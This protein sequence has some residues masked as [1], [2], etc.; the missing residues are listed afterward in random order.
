MPEYLSLP[1]LSSGVAFECVNRSPFHARYLQRNRDLWLPKMDI[2]TVAHQIL[3]ENSEDGIVTV[4]AKD[5]RTNVAKEARDAAH[6]EGKIP[7]LAGQLDDIRRMVAAA[8]EQIERMDELKGVFGTGAAEATVTWEDH[9]I[10]CKARPDYLTDQF[11]I[12][13]KTTQASC[14]PS[15]WS[16]R[17]LGPCGFDFGLMFYDR[18]LRANGIEVESRIL[19]IEQSPPYGASLIAL[20]TVRREI[21]TSKVNR[22]IQTWAKCLET[23]IFPGY[24]NSTFIAEMTPWGLAEA[25]T[26]ELNYLEAGVTA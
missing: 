6:A 19:V 17:Q 20:D 7:L 12:S 18:G 13:L 9:G 23:A 11:H 2:G 14:E 16:R 21:N 26:E 25:E 5:W 1:A 10:A 24:A 3:L 8:R 22:S 15:G 4:D